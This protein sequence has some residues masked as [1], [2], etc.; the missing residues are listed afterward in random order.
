MAICRVCGIGYEG[1]YCPKCGN[2]PTAE[3][4]CRPFGI[5]CLSL[6]RWV[7]LL[8]ALLLGYYTFFVVRWNYQFLV[9][10]I[11]LL[12]T[13]LQV[14]LYYAFTMAVKYAKGE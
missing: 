7:A 6:S 13:L 3:V 11:C 8:G 12:A 2:A 5:F 9:G 10:L 1:D 4:R 14:G